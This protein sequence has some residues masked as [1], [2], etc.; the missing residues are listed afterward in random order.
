MCSVAT[1]CSACAPPIALPSH[2]RQLR[3]NLQ[4]KVWHCHVRRKGLVI[5]PAGQPNPC[6]GPG[7]ATHHGKRGGGRAD[8]L[9]GQP[10]RLARQKVQHT[11]SST[12][13]RRCTRGSRSR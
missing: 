12:H 13:N 2:P 5:A 10:D 4:K 7:C 6:Q 8:A 1:G 3:R 11:H 9:S